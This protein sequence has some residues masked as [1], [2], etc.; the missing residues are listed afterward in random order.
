MLWTHSM[1]LIMLLAGQAGSQPQPKPDPAAQVDKVFERWNTTTSPG[2]AVSVM[3]DGRILYKRGYGMADLDHDVIITP[4][5]IF[6]VAS[7]SKQ[8]TAASILLLA[9][10]G[11]L[12]L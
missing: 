7:V 6:H 1:L 8:F 3:K 4:A 2:C 9:Q 10:E 12:S 5:S 11:K